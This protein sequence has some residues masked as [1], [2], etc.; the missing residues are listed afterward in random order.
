MEDSRLLLELG[1]IIIVTKLFMTLCMRLHIAPVFGM[2]L[3][4]VFVGKSVTGI[5]HESEVIKFIGNIGVIML[6]FIAGLETDLVTMRKTGKVSFLG[7]VG[8][9][10]VPMLGGYLLCYFFNHDTPN[11]YFTGAILTATSVSVTVMTLWE[12]GKMKSRLGSIIIN[13]SI[14]DDVI[15]L[16]VLV[17]VLSLCCGQGNPA[18]ALTKAFGFLILGSLAGYYLLPYLANW[19]N[20]LEAPQISLS[21]AFG[22][23]FLYA[24]TAHLC[25]IAPITGAYMAGLFFGRTGKRHEILKETEVFTQS[26]F[27][28]IF[29]VN[30]GLLADF[31]GIKGNWLFVFY[32]VLIACLCKIIGSGIITRLSG[33]KNR[34]AFCVGLGMMPRGEVALAIASIGI[35]AKIIGQLEFNSTIVLV[36]ISAVITPVV[37]KMFYPKDTGTKT[38]DVIKK[39]TR[40]LDAIDKKSQTT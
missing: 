16:V 7:A 28:P 14:I 30:I 9:V 39:E 25:E 40:S 17:F 31:S 35:Q 26:F 6:L 27:I 22:I 10:F 38:L 18:I 3:L 29:F 13:A 8:G 34:E 32:F 11:C 4:G 15:G 36:V 5:V 20:K 21:F 37:L 24:G 1:G 12:M 2:V 33:L 19:V 23:L